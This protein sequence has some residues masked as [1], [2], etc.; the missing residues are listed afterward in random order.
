MIAST[1]IY[2]FVPGKANEVHAAP[3]TKFDLTPNIDGM[4][5]GLYPGYKERIKVQ[6][7]MDLP[8]LW[9]QSLR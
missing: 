2:A 4:D 1:V 6:W 7:K 9:K 5:D 3:G 8:N